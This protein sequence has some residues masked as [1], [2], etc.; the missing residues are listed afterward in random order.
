MLLASIALTVGASF[1]APANTI[2]AEESAQGWTLL[3]DGHSSAGWL[4]VAGHPFPATSWKI[5]DGCLVAFNPGN[6]FQD[7]RTAATFLNFE[8][9]FEWKLL[10]DGNS[11]LKYMVQRADRWTNN[12]GLQSRAR[13]LE[14]QIVDN[15]SKDAREPSLTVGALYHVLPPVEQHARPVGE[16][17]Q[18]RLLVRGPHVEHWLNGVKVLEFETTNPEVWKNVGKLD[19]PP[20]PGVA[21]FLAL[22][23]HGTPAWFRNLKIRRLD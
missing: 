17:N 2:T 6:G 12:I 9:T 14:Y 13:G 5:E 7:I 8:F 10:K 1:G 20:P 23:N 16:F 19:A 18:S 22:Q 15:D 4:D 11:G 21:T 3:F